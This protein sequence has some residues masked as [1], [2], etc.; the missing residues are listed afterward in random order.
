MTSLPFSYLPSPDIHKPRA[1]DWIVVWNGAAQCAVVGHVVNKNVACNDVIIA[2]GV[3]YV[4][5]DLVSPSYLSSIVAECPGCSF[6]VAKYNNIWN[7]Q[8]RGLYTAYACTFRVD[9]DL[10]V[11]VPHVV[12]VKGTD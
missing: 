8:R 6:N 9:V 10:C 7:D 3:H 1:K 12:T 11:K 5:N 4:D 2:H